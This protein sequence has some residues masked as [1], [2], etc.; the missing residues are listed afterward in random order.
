MNLHTD[1]LTGAAR[2][3]VAK[4]RLAVVFD[5]VIEIPAK[6]VTHPLS[7]KTRFERNDHYF[8]IWK[9]IRLKPIDLFRLRGLLPR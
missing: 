2:V 8:C 1:K 7:W 9:G 5:F 6:R 3:K 4:Q